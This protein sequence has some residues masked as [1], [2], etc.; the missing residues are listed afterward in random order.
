MEGDRM[1][2]GHRFL[3]ERRRF[4]KLVLLAPLAPVLG[5]WRVP[6]AAALLL[7]APTPAIPDDDEP[8]P[9][10]TEGPFFKPR[11]P[12]RRSLI[13]RDLSGTRLAVSG[14]VLERTGRPV[15]GALLDF[16]Q[17]DDDGRYDNVGFRLR[18]HQY[19]DAEGRFRLDTIVPG[20]YPGRARHI[21]VK[22]QAPHRP[23]LTTQLYFPNEPRNERDGLFDDRLVMSLREEGAAKAGAFDFVLR[24]R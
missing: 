22:V 5:L 23:V 21:H 18:G 11:S 24:A 9:S 3:S 17:A 6:P 16:W 15:K 19:A 12:E 20:Q 13:E 7:L 2:T 14:R 1:T 4:L 10:A 8:T